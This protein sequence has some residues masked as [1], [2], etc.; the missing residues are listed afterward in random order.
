MAQEV[1]PGGAE[2]AASGLKGPLRE[3]VQERQGRDP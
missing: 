3:G 1:E 2:G